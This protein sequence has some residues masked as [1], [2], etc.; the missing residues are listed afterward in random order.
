MRLDVTVQNLLGYNLLDPVRRTY[1]HP[2][3][4]EASGA[5]NLPWDRPG[6]P[7]ADANVPFVPQR[8]RFL[9]FKL[10]FDL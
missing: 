7:F 8:P 1:Y 2:G 9:L 6:R 4:R 5:F 3:A 10:T